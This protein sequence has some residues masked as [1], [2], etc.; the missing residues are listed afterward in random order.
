M[1]GAEADLVR[2]LTALS[3][4]ERSCAPTPE[5]PAPTQK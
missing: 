5:W 1:F 4:I 2:H 3:I